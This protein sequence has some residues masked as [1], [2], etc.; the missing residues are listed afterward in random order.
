MHFAIFAI[1]LDVDETILFKWALGILFSLGFMCR[2]RHSY[3]IVYTTFR[4]N[5]LLMSF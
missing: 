5:L 2:K 3:K 4:P 1:C